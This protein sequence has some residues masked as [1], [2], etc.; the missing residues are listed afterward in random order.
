VVREWFEHRNARVVAE[1][2]NL[3]EATED[4]IR[5]VLYG[6]SV[7]NVGVYRDCQCALVDEFGGNDSGGTILYI[8]HDD[9]GSGLGE[10]MGHASS[11]AAT[12]SSYD[13]NL[14]CESLHQMLSLS[15]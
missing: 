10:C 4:S 11:D 13:R 1:D 15:R 3:T 5:E 2:M 12:G 7:R 8:G 6:G 14:A 9:L